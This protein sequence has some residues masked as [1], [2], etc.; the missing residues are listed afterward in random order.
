MELEIKERIAQKIFG[1]LLE[2]SGYKL[3]AIDHGQS[4]QGMI[5]GT[6]KAH[7]PSYLN[8][9]N[10]YGD[11][12]LVL[13]KTPMS[14]QI[15]LV[16]QINKEEYV[17]H[18]KGEAAVVFITPRKPFFRIAW[19]SEFLQTGET[20]PLEGNSIL[21]IKKGMISKYSKQIER[22]LK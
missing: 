2:E 22:M 5:T 3:E 15:K 7:Y 18:C 20:Q 9:I 10:R 4:L 13:G 6:K 16:A 21:K 17:P 8:D 12:F 14:L 11:V 1:Q 19:I